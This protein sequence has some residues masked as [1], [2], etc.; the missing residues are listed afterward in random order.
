MRERR[1][2]LVFHPAL[3]PYRVDFFNA[4]NKAFNAAFYFNL[5]NV[6]DQKFNQE[7]LADKCHFKLNF[8]QNGFDFFGRSFRFGILKI[9]RKE[10]PD[11]I[12]CSE[13]GQ[14]TLVVFLYK[15][16]FRKQFSL[17][18][19]SDDSI[20]NSKS[21]KGLRAILRN[22]IA[23][24]CDGV[25]FP[26]SEVCNWFKDNISNV[27]KTLELPIIHNDE[28]FRNELVASLEVANQNIINFNLEGKKVI[29]FV[30]RLVE[31]KNL[32]LLVNVIAQI[33]TT[34]WV[35]VMVGEGILMDDLKSQVMN[36]N[37]STSV[38][39]VGRQEEWELVSWYI[40]AQIF[41]LPS[42]YERFGAV[43][44]E[45]LLGGCKVLC[46]ETA[47]ASI[48]INNKNGELFSPYKESEL[49]FCLENSLSESIITPN[50]INKIRESNMPFTFNEKI[51]FLINNL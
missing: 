32:A 49:L 34:D 36:L 12:L 17:Y 10:L 6:S 35:L 23:K 22:V 18:T 47:G 27:T 40:L 30:G 7:K 37:I 3:A 24:N 42:T 13:Y 4:I 43:V 8:I 45:A 16:L 11:I 21:R 39:F 28:V 33:K 29:L 38:H 1:K 51:E 46:S 26:S 19:I 9:L 2:I 44:N 15:I 48:L 25:I 14:V 31:V 50:S 20:E 41:V 5:A